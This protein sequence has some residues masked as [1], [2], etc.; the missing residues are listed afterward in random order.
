MIAVIALVIRV[1]ISLITPAN[2][3]D[4]VV[5]PPMPMYS[6]EVAESHEWVAY[7]HDAYCE[8]ADEFT[9]LF[10]SYEVKHAKNG[11]LMIRRGDS[12]SYKFCK[13][14]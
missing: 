5:I 3:V 10:N 6:P 14:G 4:V 11:A 8:Y 7:S 12:G 1:L 13:R 9:A 2:N